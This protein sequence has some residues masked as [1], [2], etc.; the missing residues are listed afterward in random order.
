VEQPAT[1][2]VERATAYLVTYFFVGPVLI[3]GEENLPARNDD[4]ANKVSYVFI[5]NHNSQ[6]DLCVVYFIRRRFKWIMKQSIVYLPGV[7]LL[8]RMARHVF[9][10][11]TKGNNKESVKKMYAEAAKALV[12]GKSIFI[13]PQGTRA[14]VGRLPFKDGAFNI[15]MESQVP[16]VPISIQ[17]PKMAWNN[18]Y[19]FNLLWNK[20]IE[21]VVLTI[22]KAIPVTKDSNKEAL[23]EECFNVIY[24]EL[25]N[26]GIS[27]K[28]E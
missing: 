5:A 26:I 25:P 9:I 17:I 14:M 19:P 3:R 8:M 18:A 1:V 11:R 23:K 6:I 13:F 12:N 28:S 2:W 21:P 4:N 16:I 24:S 22:H 10:N 20:N 7:G 15:A 27:K